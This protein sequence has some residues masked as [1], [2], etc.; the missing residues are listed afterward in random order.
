M[1]LHKHTKQQRKAI[2]RR[3]KQKAQRVKQKR[4]KAVDF[5]EA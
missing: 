5:Q 4:G 1:T 3:N 2:R